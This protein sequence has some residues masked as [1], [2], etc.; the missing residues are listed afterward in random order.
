M[1]FLEVFVRRPVFTTMLVASLVVLGGAS[2][3]QLGVDIFPKVD[4]PTITITTRLP[5]AAPEEIESQ[6]TKPIEEAVNTI[7]GLDELRSSTIEGQSQVFATFVLERNVQEAANDVREKVS[8]I[9]SR[10]PAGTESPIVEKFDPDSAPVLAIVVSGARSAREITEIADKRIKRALETVRDVGAITLVGDRKREIQVLAD[11]NKLTALG[12]SIHQVKDALLRQ[13]VEIPGGRLTAGAH[14]EGLRTLGRVESVEAFNE[15][16]VADRKGS[17]IRLSEV[18]TVVDGEEE[19]RTLSRLNG[20]SAVSLLIRKQSGT[21]TVAV[22][23]AVKARLAE[24]QRTLPQDIQFQIVRDLS[25]F[26]KRS[27]HEIQDHL[28][29][30]GLL[31]SLIV[32]AFI[33]RLRWWEGAVLLAIV[34][35]VAAA[36]AV[37]RPE[38]LIQVTGAAIVATMVFFLAVRRLRPAF[39]A[40]LAIPCSIIATF[41]AMR[42]AGFTLNN[43]TMLGLSLSTGI[44]I[45][46]AIIVLEN[47]FRHV[48]EERRP[49]FEAA[50]TGTREISLAVSATTVSLVV[51]FLPVAFMGGLVGRFWNSFGLTATYAIMVSLVIA[52]TLTPMLAARIIA[53]HHATDGPRGPTAPASKATGL[54][55]ALE[56][57]YERAL[58]WCLR[59]RALCLL[60]SLAILAG[61]YYLLVTA[62]LEF[63]VDDD[64]SEFEVVAEA[65]PGSSLE[66]SVEIARTM[67]TAIREIPEVT[68]LFTNIGVRG[69]YRSNVTDLS[70]YVGLTHLVERRR[71]QAE[72]MQAVRERL[73]TLPGL[74]VSVQNLSIIGG[75]GFRQTPFNLILRGPDLSRL[76]QY[77]ANVIRELRGRP[78][79]VDLDTAQALRQPEIQVHID[80]QKASDLGIRVEAVASALR[81][82]VG[83][84]KVGFFRE[85]G[86]QYDVRLRLREEFRSDVTGLAALAVASADGS[87]VRL[88]NVTSLGPGMGPGQIERYAQERSVTIISN[89]YRK[90]LA[91]AFRDAYAAVGRQK[92][93]AEYGIQASGRGKLLQE[94]LQ[95]FLIAFVLSLAF[96][97]IVL[98]AQFESFVHPLTIMVSM[99][100]SIPFGL[101]TLLV[102]GKTLNIYSIMGLFL[103]MGVV[104]KN[105]ILQVD[106]TNVLRER[107]LPRSEAQMEADRARLRP[108]LMTTLAI[109]AGMLPVALGKGDGSASRASLAAAVVGGQALCLLVTLLMT[110]VIYST[111]DDL[112]GIRTPAWLRVPRWKAALERRGVLWGEGRLAARPAGSEGPPRG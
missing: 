101:L 75:G 86:E 105:A 112:R 38:L 35:A 83:G 36:F 48:E 90:P 110:P 104:K 40:A 34:T 43:L 18:A 79:F 57:G 45:D 97:Y 51:I 15:L 91:E 102:V 52:F 10:L 62:R 19:P 5:G 29:L 24:V 17:P 54:Y 13:N 71:S 69:Q 80:R 2:F 100:L 58:G 95:N 9:L 68:T 72:I 64:M 16:I 106:Y 103:L 55:H 70:I 93:P 6:I 81:I 27:F 99:F 88:A 22:V 111:F 12:L 28:L 98:A 59:H 73:A 41:T 30:G 44:V 77:A 76:E 107:G 23:D 63:V 108:I 78:G 74:R 67:E 61:G 87:L 65:P 31:A 33:G 53:R 47:I 84:E 4:L 82:M 92:M 42:L 50:I 46:D 60:G 94:A 3:L 56:G 85:L 96:I 39:V 14:E 66:R 7:T 32:A 89:L 37:G 109:I 21:N 11:P 49:P 26:I 20:R 8:A 25:R 1:G